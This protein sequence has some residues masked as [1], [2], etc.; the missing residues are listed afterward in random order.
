MDNFG[1]YRGKKD[2]GNEWIFGQLIKVENYQDYTIIATS[3]KR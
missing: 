1:F 3:F 2:Y